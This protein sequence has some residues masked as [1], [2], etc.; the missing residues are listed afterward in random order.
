[1]TVN[2]LDDEAPAF[3]SSATPSV[4]E[5]VRDVVSLS[6]TDSDSSGSASFAITGG[7]DNTLF[8]INE[9]TL[10]F[11]SAAGQNYEHDLCIESMRSGRQSH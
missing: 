11:V 6:V 1:M 2:N 5:N 4:A 8:E 7:A 9:G 10:R 3:S